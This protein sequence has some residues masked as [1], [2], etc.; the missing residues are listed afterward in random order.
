MK[1]RTD[2]DDYLARMRAA[3]TGMTLDEREDIVAEI[4]MHIRERSEEDAGAV[5]EILAALGPAERLAEQYRT[6]M[7]LQRAQRSVSPVVILRASLRWA[8]TGVQGTTVFLAAL[9]GYLSGAGFLVLAVIKPL[10]PRYTGLWLGPDRFDFS[11]GFRDD[12][13]SVHLHEVLGWWFIPVAL[14][15]GSMTLLLTTKLIQRL[16]KRFRWRLP[17]LLNTPVS[18]VTH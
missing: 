13:A 1:P 14:I 7:L 18:L 3:L 8:K 12:Y 9:L 15:L 6:G 10:F 5:P 17:T 2:M 16:A 11:F 4:R